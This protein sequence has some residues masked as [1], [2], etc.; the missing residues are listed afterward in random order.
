MGTIVVNDVSAVTPEIWSAVLQD[1]LYKSLVSFGIANVQTR[2]VLRVGDTINK[3][4]IATVTAAAYTPGTTISIDEMDYVTDQLVV[5]NKYYT[6]SYVDDYE[7]LQANIELARP[8][9][10]EQSYQLKVLID[11]ATLN[12]TSAGI[13]AGMSIIYGSTKGDSH[14]ATL[15]ATTANIVN[16]FAGARAI[17]LD[18]QCED[19]GDFAAVLAPRE[20]YLLALKST[21][22]GFNF[23]DATLRNGYVG[24]FMGFQVYVSNNLTSVTDISAENAVL[25]TNSTETVRHLYFGRKGQIELLMQQAPKIDIKEVSDQIGKNIICSTCWGD[26]VYTRNKSRFLQVYTDITASV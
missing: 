11:S 15:T 22:L 2:D 4:Y 17:L 20:A 24:D 8:L 10:D 3:Q 21:G 16:V 12:N 26:T 14:L 23:A 13:T 18:N 5:N 25:S 7:Q 19:M 1:N 9:M 6:A